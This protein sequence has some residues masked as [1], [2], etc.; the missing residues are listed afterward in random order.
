MKKKR[1]LKKKFKCFFGLYLIFIFFVIIKTSMGKYTSSLG[2]KSTTLT[3]AKPVIKLNVETPISIDVVNGGDIV[4]YFSVSNKDNNVVT[5]V[6]L[7]Y[8]IYVVDENDNLINN[9]HIY[10]QTDNDNPNEFQE[11]T[12]ISS[13]DYSG[14]FETSGFA[15]NEEIHNYKLVVNN[16]S[17]FNQV[18]IKVKAVQK[19][20]S[21]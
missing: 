21:E 9:A 5:E 15:I 6:G 3:V 17:G 14:Y 8:Y 16:V 7:D 18:N 4:R 1:V 12:R 2:E 20:V 13:G 10:F 19:R 11:L